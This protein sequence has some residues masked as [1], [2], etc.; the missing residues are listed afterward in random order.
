MSARDRFAPAQPEYETQVRNGT[1]SMP[2]SRFFGIE[3]V[4][5]EPGRVELVLPYR[6]E[7]GFK[8]GHFQGTV[9][10]AAGYFAATASISSLLPGDRIGM[11]LDQTT[12]FLGLAAGERLIAR[13]RAVAPG[14]SVSVGAADVFVLRD[15][16][17]HL[18]ATVLVT[19]CNVER[20]ATPPV[21]AKGGAA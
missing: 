13:G 3:P 4:A 15:G 5:I 21:V 11:S 19:T 20:P 12:K 16:A 17:E 6:D 1:F 8:P 2:V 18:C 7:L 14:R 10:S 9:V